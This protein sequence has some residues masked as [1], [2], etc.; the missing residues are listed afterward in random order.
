MEKKGFE[1]RMKECGGD[2]RLRYVMSEDKVGAFYWDTV[3][4]FTSL[5][6]GSWNL[7]SRQQQAAHGTK[8]LSRCPGI[9]HHSQAEEEP[10]LWL[11]TH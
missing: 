3:Y 10:G 7:Q 9:V 11:E 4:V 6:F 1:A 2:G 8:T 5:G